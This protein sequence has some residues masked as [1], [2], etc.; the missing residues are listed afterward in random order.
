MRQ[1]HT[2]TSHVRLVPIDRLL[3]AGCICAWAGCPRAFKG[4]MPH[5]WT[6]LQMYH[7]PQVTADPLQR[8]W[9]RDAVLC[10]E[11]TLKIDVQ[12]KRIPR[13]AE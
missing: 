5:G 3:K 1:M 12:L 11:H 6:W 4:E 10:P 8:D 9:L 7:S 2:A 13:N